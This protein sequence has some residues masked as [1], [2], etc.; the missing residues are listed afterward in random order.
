M[1]RQCSVDSHRRLVITSLSFQR[2]TLPPLTGELLELSPQSRTRDSADP[3]GLSHPLV[4]SKVNTSSR[5]AILSASRSSS[6]LTVSLAATAAVAAGN[7]RPSSTGK[8]TRLRRRKPTNTLP[9]TELASTLKH[10]QL[11]LI[12]LD[13]RTF[14]RATLPR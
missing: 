9:G 3:A 14:S 1:G 7:T 8:R 13:T 12:P 10:R 4:P 11:V 5:P 6:S 2:P